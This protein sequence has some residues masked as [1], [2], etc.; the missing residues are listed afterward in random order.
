MTLRRSL[1]LPLAV[2][3]L[4][5][6][7]ASGE[8]AAPATSPA[9]TV[10]VRTPAADRVVERSPLADLVVELDNARYDAREQ[11]SRASYPVSVRIDAIGI[12]GANIVPVGV[13]PAGALEVP[14]AETVGWYR[15]G[16]APGAAGTAALAAHVAFNGRDGVFR[17]LEDVAAGDPVV[18]VMSD[19]SE[20]TYRV[21]T[22]EQYPKQDLPDAVWSRTGPERL[23]L[24]TCGGRFDRD[25]RRYADN[26]IAWASPA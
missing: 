26:V 3:A 4:A 19:G 17:N 18:V 16:A 2:V 8:R 7:G 24:I 6:C 15:F 22:V 25:R 5:G 21:E 11:R 9:D 10:P 20:R 12:S 14:G 23:A 1:A 13:D